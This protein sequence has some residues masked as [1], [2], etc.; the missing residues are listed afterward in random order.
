[1]ENHAELFSLDNLLHH[2]LQGIKN[3]DFVSFVFFCGNIPHLIKLLFFKAVILIQEHE[4]VVA[5]L[6]H[7]LV[8][9]TTEKVVEDINMIEPL[10]HSFFC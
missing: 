2:I 3:Y 8:H 5:F 1:M 10:N 4:K 6:N 9:T 7:L